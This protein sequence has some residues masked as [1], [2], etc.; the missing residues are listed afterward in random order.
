MYIWM[1]V[2]MCVYIYIYICIYIYIYIAGHHILSFWVVSWC[3]G[4]GIAAKRR[5]DNPI[6]DPV[7]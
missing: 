7:H 3:S 5:I 1:H 2:H 6:V 4:G